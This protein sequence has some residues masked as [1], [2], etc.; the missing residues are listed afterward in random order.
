VEPTN[1]GAHLPHR[2]EHDQCRTVG[3]AREGARESRPA[4]RRGAGLW[5]PGR[6]SRRSA[7]R[8]YRRIRGRDRRGNSLFDAIGQKTFV[9]SETPKAANLAL[10]EAMAAGRR[11]PCRR[12][13]LSLTHQ[14][15]NILTSTLF[16][17]PVYKTYGALIVGQKIFDGRA[18]F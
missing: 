15:L 14:Y 3:G 16:S 7:L 5:A 12:A 1:S 9:V 2:L 17:A 8:Y 13:P 6:R 4:F 10:G 18:S 11:R